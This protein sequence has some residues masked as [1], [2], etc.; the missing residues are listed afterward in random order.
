MYVAIPTIVPSRL[1]MRGIYLFTT[2]GNLTL[3]A[4]NPKP[5]EARL[6]APESDARFDVPRA[7]AY[8]RPGVIMTDRCIPAVVHGGRSR[9]ARIAEALWPFERRGSVF[10]FPVDYVSLA[11]DILGFAAAIVTFIITAKS[12]E[13][14]TIDQTNKERVR[15]TL[16]DFATLRR[17]HQ[18][19]G[20]KLP[21]SGSMEQRDLKEYLSNLERFA[22]GCNM[23]A[24]DLEV[25]S[26]MSGGQLI[27]H[28]Q[29]YFR[30]YI[31]ER[32][33]N[34]RIDGAISDVNAIYIEFENM[35]KELHDLRGV[36]W[37]APEHVS[38]EHHILHH[39]LHLPVSTSE[40]VFAR[41][42][43]LRGAIESHGEGKQGYLYVPG[44][45][46]DRCLLVAHADTYFD[47]AYRE[48]SGDAALEACVVRDG[49]VY[50]SGTNACGI[51]ADDRAGCA[52]LW[53]LRNSGHSLLVLDGE[54]HGQIGAHFLE[55]SNPRLFDEI[56]RHTFMLQLDRRGASDYKT[57]GIPVTADFLSFIERETGYVRTEGTGKTDIGTLCRDVCGVNLSVGYY[58]E[59]HPEETLV[60]AEWERTLNIVRTMLDKDLA[61]FPVAR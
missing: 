7:R 53:L 24:Y 12:D 18:Y 30:D 27:R 49:G 17:E 14:A 60:V 54:E 25:V 40:P 61:R 55:A 58:N 1:V 9:H 47:Q 20:R 43:H 33:L 48:D 50:R 29:R 45:R 51:G 3:T 32:R 52:M 11:I 38:E 19:F 37:R 39:F 42:R 31:T 26:R 34:Y 36:E 15:A 46:P 13:Q 28:Y 57:Y 10:G 21:A 41:F 22:V 8:A 6:S 2:L 59:H 44:T 35:M 4:Y 16:T 23:G 5:S 56:N